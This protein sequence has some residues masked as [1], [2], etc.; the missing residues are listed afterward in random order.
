MLP[1]LRESGAIEQ[2]ADVVIDLL[3]LKNLPTALM[4]ERL[5]STSSSSKT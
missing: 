5:E 3:E 4:L 1:N 2:D